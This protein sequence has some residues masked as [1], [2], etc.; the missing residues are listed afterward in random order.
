RHDAIVAAGGNAIT[1]TNPENE[2]VVAAMASIPAVN[3][4]VF[5]EQPEAEAFEPIYTAL[6]R[7]GGLLLIATAFAGTLAYWFAARMTRPIRLLEEGA[8]R[9]GIGQLDQRIDITTGD[10]LE[11]IAAQ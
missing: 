6:W 7:T 11:R 2:T 10:E 4:T 5:V 3:W 9:I 1:I 8:D